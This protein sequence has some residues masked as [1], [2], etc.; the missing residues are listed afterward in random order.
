MIN[1]P[2]AEGLCCIEIAILCN[3]AVEVVY[4]LRKSSE[5]YWKSLGRSLSSLSGK[6]LVDEVVAAMALRG[7]LIGS[8]TT[9]VPGR[10]TTT[11]TAKTATN[12]SISEGTTTTCTTATV[13][14]ARAITSTTID[15]HW[16]H[17]PLRRGNSWWR[18]RKCT[19]L[20]DYLSQTKQGPL[21]AGFLVPAEEALDDDDTKINTD[22]KQ[23]TEKP[24]PERAWAKYDVVSIGCCFIDDNDD[25]VGKNDEDGDSNDGRKKSSDMARSN[26]NGS[27]ASSSSSSLSSGAIPLTE[28]DRH[29]NI[30]GTA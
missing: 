5:A 23:K 29:T 12:I 26:S 13:L 9:T 11:T 17:P 16:H 8:P 18:Q 25:D 19:A 10:S 14:T 24:S 6:R 22:N 2:E 4:L 21:L 7:M 1:R 15:Q 20:S 28:K 27:V 30:A 3:A